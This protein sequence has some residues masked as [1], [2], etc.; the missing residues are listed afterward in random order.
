MGLKF[1]NFGKAI[2]ASAPSGT[3]GL[4]FTVQAGTGLLFPSL[5]A[6]DYFYGIF[7]DASGNHE[8]VKVSARSTDAMTIATGGR[9]LDGT[10]ARTWA[11]GDYF[12]AGISNIALLESLGNANL[13]AIGALA[14]APDQL[15]YFTGSGTAA[16]AG[17]SAFVRTLLDDPDGATFL[18]TLIASST[19][20]TARSTLGLGSIA[21]QAA[22]AVAITGGTV[23][24]ITD[25]AIADGGTGASTAAAA[26]AALKQQ[27]DS[28]TTGVWRSGTNAEQLAGSL[29]TV[30][31]TPAGLASSQSLAQNG[32]TKLPGG[33]IEQ[34]GIAAV[35][36]DIPAGGMT[37]TITFAIAFPTSLYNV[38]AIPYS[39]DASSA[40]NI[41]VVLVSTTSSQA[42]FY[43]F[44]GVSTTQASWGIYYR[45]NG[46]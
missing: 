38:V 20:A 8:I 40:R 42:T 37:F 19:A 15:P 43:A 44:E 10:T 25:L 12:V 2:V 9:G 35:N 24:G 31:C 7:K 11:A 5:G 23:A 32:Y 29:T 16:L 22:S 21:T 26:F 27:G 41:M 14:S 39:L 3:G 4:S 6:G 17:L 1:S 46:K 34:W 33:L 13:Q 18:T 36:A 28:S 30:G 45:V